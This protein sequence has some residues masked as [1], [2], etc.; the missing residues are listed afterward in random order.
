MRAELVH[1]SNYQVSEGSPSL[2]ICTLMND[3]IEQS[4]QTVGR[5]LICYHSFS[6]NHPPLPPPTPQTTCPGLMKFKVVSGFRLHQNGL[7][8]AE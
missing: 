3:S 7:E 5:G 8:M 4:E 6:S 1:L 2:P